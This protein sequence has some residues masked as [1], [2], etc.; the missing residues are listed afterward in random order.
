MTNIFFF[1]LPIVTVTHVSP[2]LWPVHSL[3]ESFNVPKTYFATLVQP[4]LATNDERSTSKIMI[5]QG[6]EII[7]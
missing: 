7:V 1:F 2:T 5:V 6:I 4:K 3:S